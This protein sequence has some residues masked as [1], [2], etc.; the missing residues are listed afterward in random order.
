MTETALKRFGQKYK[1][2]VF[3]VEHIEYNFPHAGDVM[4]DIDA[5]ILE[6]DCLRVMPAEIKAAS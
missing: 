6:Y 2:A 3:T 1:G 5:P 4:Y